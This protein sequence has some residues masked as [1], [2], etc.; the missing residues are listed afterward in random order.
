MAKALFIT[1]SLFI[2]FA[3]GQWCHS[4]GYTLDRGWSW[5]R[6]QIPAKHLKQLEAFTAEPKLGSLWKK[7]DSLVPRPIPRQIP[8]SSP[9]APPT[10]LGNPAGPSALKPEPKKQTPEIDEEGL[11]PTDREALI[12]LLK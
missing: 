2:I 11:S 10:T 7:T 3:L 8:G 1:G 6:A 5:V 4:E 9:K 12:G